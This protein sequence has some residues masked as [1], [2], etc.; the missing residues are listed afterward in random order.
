[1]MR[2][3]GCDGVMIGRGALGAPWVFMP[4]APW[5]TLAFRMKALARHLELIEKFFPTEK[6]LGKTQNHAGRYFKGTRGGAAIRQ[7]I[8]E[9]KSFTEL[10]ELIGSM[11]MPPTE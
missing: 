6:I 8:Y 1:M 11:E 2:A 3:T 4:N 7:K 9:V 5:P 10:R